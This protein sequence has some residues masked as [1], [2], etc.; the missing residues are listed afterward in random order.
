M[1]TVQKLR[2]KDQIK[3]KELPGG[4]KEKEM[5]LLMMHYL[6]HADEGPGWSQ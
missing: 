4:I 5:T 1:E 3:E 2:N 6:R